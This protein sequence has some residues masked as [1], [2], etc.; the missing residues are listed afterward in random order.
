M[1]VALYA[2]LTLRVPLP[3]FRG[4][5]SRELSYSNSAEEPSISHPSM[6]SSPASRTT[7]SSPC[8]TGSRSRVQE[9]AMD[10]FSKSMPSST[11]MC[12]VWNSLGG[13]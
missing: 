6:S 11:L 9:P 3:A 5:D 10:F 13:G 12:L 2:T 4:I 8:L 7:L 1:G